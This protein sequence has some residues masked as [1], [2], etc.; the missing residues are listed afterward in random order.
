VEPG[1]ITIGM[2]VEACWE[3]RSDEVAVLK[4]RPVIRV[5]LPANGPERS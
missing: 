5:E 1:S 3:R 2:P 4:F